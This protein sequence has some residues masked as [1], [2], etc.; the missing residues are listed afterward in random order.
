M[1]IQVKDE[2]M[3]LSNDYTT[4]VNRKTIIV[5]EHFYRWA[6]G[7]LLSFNLL[8]NLMTASG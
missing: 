2:Y 3:I 1:S 7:K 8:M 6:I 4:M 5:F